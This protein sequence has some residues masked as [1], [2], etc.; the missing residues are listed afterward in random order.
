MSPEEKLSELHGHMKTIVESLLAVSE[1]NGCSLDAFLAIIPALGANGLIEKKP[2]GTSP[3]MDALKGQHAQLYALNTSIAKLIRAFDM[4][5]MESR[6]SPKPEGDPDPKGP[7]DLKPR[8]DPK[9][10]AK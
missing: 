9:D 2:D 10:P 4:D 8:T 6:L 5:G 3:L 7:R 1:A